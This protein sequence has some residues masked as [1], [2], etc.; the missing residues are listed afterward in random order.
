[1]SLHENDNLWAVLVGESDI[2]SVGTA[3]EMALSLEKEPLMRSA[4]LLR[5]LSET[6]EV[7]RALPL[8]TEADECVVIPAH[9]LLSLTCAAMARL[10]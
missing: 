1:M 8:H 6:R 3:S 10:R 2:Y 7:L 9:V 5:A 4:A